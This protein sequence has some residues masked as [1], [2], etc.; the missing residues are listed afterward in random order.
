MHKSQITRTDGNRSSH[1]N[2]VG[3][4]HKPIGRANSNTT[5][6][7]EN[8]S[9]HLFLNKLIDTLKQNDKY[10][11]KELA[12]HLRQNFSKMMTTNDQIVCDMIT[13][14]RN[15]SS[16]GAAKIQRE[17]LSLSERM[18]ANPEEFT[19]TSIETIYNDVKD[20]MRT[21][22]G[23]NKVQEKNSLETDLLSL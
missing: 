3:E 22:C 1:E 9:S 20:K 19:K 14:R 18:Q 11:Q 6:L 10:D 13:P 21:Y 16:A 7:S 12:E 17:N 15:S 5:F 8:F 2:V 23:H 4:G